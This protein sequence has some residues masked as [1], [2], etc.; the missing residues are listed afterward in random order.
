[1]SGKLAEFLCPSECVGQQDFVGFDYYWGIPAIRIER[2]QRL[3]DA[4]AGDFSRAPVH[5]E[6]LYSH[7]VEHARLF[8]GLPLLII[9]N[10]SVDM[11]D[12]VGRTD[13]L[14]KHIQQVVRAVSQGINVHAYICWSLTSNREWGLP[15]GQSSDFG[16]YHIDLDTDPGLQRIPTPAA[17]VYTS[18]IRGRGVEATRST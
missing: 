9:E 14:K 1:M 18:I 16:L 11:A 8:P 10:G 17:D 6:A 5:P 12:N 13:Y 2:I 4:A 7:L 3:L 15:F